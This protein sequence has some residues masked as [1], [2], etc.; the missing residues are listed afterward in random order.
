MRHV[1]KLCDSGDGRNQTSSLLQDLEPA[2]VH[3][4]RN[5]MAYIIFQVGQWGRVRGLITGM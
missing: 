2:A 1:F 3:V 5:D 4:D